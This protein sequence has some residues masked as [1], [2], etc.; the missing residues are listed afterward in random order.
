MK[1]PSKL[2]TVYSEI[3]IEIPQS[4]FKI[5][6]VTHGYSMESL[7]LTST[8]RSIKKGICGVYKTFFTHS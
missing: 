5:Q 8:L 6:N 4:Q 2:A 3:K 1:W 7:V